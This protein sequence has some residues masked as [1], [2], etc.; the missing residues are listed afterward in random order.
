VWW[1]VMLCLTH[2]AS[3]ARGPAQ[4]G[5]RRSSRLGGGGDPCAGLLPTA[6]HLAHTIARVEQAQVVF[7]PYPHV[8]AYSPC[9]W[10]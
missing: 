1:V 6:Q 9:R 2:R 8:R 7:T 10:G 3:A 4:R 5:R